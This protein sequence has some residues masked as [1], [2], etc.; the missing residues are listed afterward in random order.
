MRNVS[1]DPETDLSPDDLVQWRAAVTRGERAR[2]D[3]IRIKSNGKIAKFDATIWATFKRLMLASAYHNKCGYC[4]TDTS[5]GA[6]YDADHWRPKGQVTRLGGEGE[7]VPVPHP[8]YYWL[9]YSWQNIVPSC[10]R[11]NSERKRTH[12]PIDRDYCTSH[13]GNLLPATLDASERP[14]LCHPSST[15]HP[16]EKHIGFDEFGRAFAIKNSSYGHHSI[17]VYGLDRLDDVRHAEQRRAYA[18]V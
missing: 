17:R 16:P 8:G 4:E 5:A 2:D 7:T 1:F 6:P 12:F 14:L 10:Q 18:A 13:E 15:T 9:A 3:V 11:C